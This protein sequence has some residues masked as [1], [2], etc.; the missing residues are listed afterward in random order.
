M[1][2]NQLAYVVVESTDVEKWRFFGTQIIGLAE[3]KAA[4]GALYLK[5]D[6]RRYRILVV[7]GARD[8]LFASGWETVN[9]GQYLAARESVARAGVEIIESSPLDRQLR[10]VIGMFSFVDPSGN[11]QEV[12]WGPISD[13]APFISPVGVERFVTGQMGMGHVVLPSMKFDESLQFWTDV[14]GFGLSDILHAQLSPEYRA[15]IYFMHCNPRQHSLALAEMPQP[16]G[17][18]HIMLEVPGI[19]DVGRALDRIARH[20]VPLAA[21]LGR[22]VN[23]EMVSFYVW[24]PGGF[25]LEFG[26]G[27]L[28]KDW[29]N[30]HT[31]FETTRGSHWGHHWA[32]PP[33]Q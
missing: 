22:H 14:C 6:D 21:T 20:N 33:A 16:S 5:A 26:C 17:C 31:V 18:V 10:C 32:A 13:F 3:D 2:I 8:G 7:P 1:S 15:R 25:A 12:T 28:V 23:D 30:D 9:E 27:G 29:E 24:T 19:D 4:D 11:R